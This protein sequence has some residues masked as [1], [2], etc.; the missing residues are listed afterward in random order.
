MQ[1]KL[2]AINYASCTCLQSI[3]QSIKQ[4]SCVKQVVQSIMQVVQSIKQFVQS[5]LCNQLCKLCN[6]LN[7]L[8]KES[9]VQSIMQV[10]QSIMQVVQSIMQV[11]LIF[12]VVQV[13][14]IFA[15]ARMDMTPVQ[16]VELFLHKEHLRQQID[17][18]K[19]DRLASITFRYATP[20]HKQT[21]NPSACKKQK[22]SPPVID[23][24]SDSEEE[25]AAAHAS[26]TA[27]AVADSCHRDFKP[28]PT[29][30]QLQVPK[31]IRVEWARIERLWHDGETDAPCCTAAN[32]PYSGGGPLQNRYH[33][34]ERLVELEHFLWGK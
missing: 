16:E 30:E 17:K 19:H 10:V 12:V 4:A 2:C 26:A 8:C 9:C 24:V 7:K 5:K 18:R 3:K 6:Q 33:L 22:K 13:V 25:A 14:T 28:P 15:R 23:I 32:C 34:I 29:V 21:T 20:T 11:V 1:R 27:S 31:T